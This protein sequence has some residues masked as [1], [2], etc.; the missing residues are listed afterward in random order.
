MKN[1]YKVLIAGVIQPKLYATYEEAQKARIRLGGN[2]IVKIA[3][4]GT[5]EVCNL[6]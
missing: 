1:K 4:K 5:K 2:M 6:P 3:P